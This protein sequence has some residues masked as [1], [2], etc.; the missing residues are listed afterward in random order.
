MKGNRI[1][2]VAAVVLLVGLVFMFSGAASAGF[3]GARLSA[4]D[5][6]DKNYT[7]TGEITS[8]VVDD[9][10]TAVEV[11]PGDG[12]HLSVDYEDGRWERYAIEETGGELHIEKQMERDWFRTFWDFDF[13]G[14]R[15]TVRVP[16]NTVIALNVETSN[17]SIAL[18]GLGF[19]TLSLRTSNARVEME[20]VAVAQG[21]DVKSSSGSL[22]LTNVTAQGDINT[23]TSNG[24]V[25]FTGV[26]GANVV[27]DTSN[28][29][30]TL[31]DFTARG[32]DAKTSNGAISLAGVDVQQE[33][34]FT[35]S[36]GSITG[37]LAGSMKDYSIKSH[38]SNGHNNLPEEL[39]LGARSLTATTSNGRIDV[40]FE[41]D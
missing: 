8:L 21:V 30:V 23:R 37:S 28:G 4:D 3:S 26:G 7:A 36:N 29:K 31:E 17:A 38:T 20:D 32:V 27:V 35:A 34:R 24:S 41:A 39:G 2:I 9:S 5:W 14:R 25:E 19:E 10:N 22:Y 18:S 16:K 40:G 33:L 12:D 13:G 15:L 6:Q 11:V 1:Y